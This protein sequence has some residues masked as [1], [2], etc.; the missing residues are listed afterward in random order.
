MAIGRSHDHG[1][2]LG[3]LGLDCLIHPQ[4][5]LLDGIRCEGCFGQAQG[6]VVCDADL[7]SFRFTDISR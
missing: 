4:V 7:P 6:R 5:E 2:G 1:V 3:Y